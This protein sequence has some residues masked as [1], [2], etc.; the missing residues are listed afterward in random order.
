MTTT[1]PIFSPW[2]NDMKARGIV[3][4][5]SNT[6]SRTFNLPWKGEMKNTKIKIKKWQNMHCVQTKSEFWDK[7][8]LLPFIKNLCLGN[9]LAYRYQKNQHCLKIYVYL[10]QNLCFYSFCETGI[11][12]LPVVFS[13][14][15]TL[16]IFIP[17]NEKTRPTTTPVICWGH[18]I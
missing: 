7:F 2:N 14:K 6:C 15:T 13:S 8:M 3:S 11:N 5:P 16:K 10:F 18:A 9:P 1:F 12:V 17:N 4:N